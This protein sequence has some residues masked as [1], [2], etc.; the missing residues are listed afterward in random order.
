M[1]E[2]VIIVLRI[3]KTETRLFVYIYLKNSPN[4][5]RYNKEQT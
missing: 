4:N 5:V 3:V 2:S 1:C